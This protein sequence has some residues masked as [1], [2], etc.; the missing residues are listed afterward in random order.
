MA[1]I[2]DYVKWR[3]DVCINENPFNAIDALILTNFGYIHYDEMLES[4][5]KTIGQLGYE[6]QQLTEEKRESKWRVKEDQEL[7]FAMMNSSRYKYLEV[8]DYFSQHDY[9]QEMQFSAMTVHTPDHCI[10]VVFRGTDGSFVGWKEDFNMFSREE[11]P[12][13]CQAV[14]YLKEVAGKYP[15]K[16]IRVMG[17]SKGGNLAIYS[18]VKNDSAIHERM[19]R[20]YN[21]DGPGFSEGF[22]ELDAYKKMRPK[23]QM[24]VPQSS[25]F[26]MIFKHDIKMEIVKS[27]QLGIMQHD[28]YSWEVTGSAFVHVKELSTT[29]KWLENTLDHILENLTVDQRKQLVDIIYQALVDVKGDN[30]MGSWFT[31]I[32][33]FVKEAQALDETNT[34]FLTE[35]IGIF[36]GAAKNSFSETILP[37]KK[38][39]EEIVASHPFY[40]L[41]NVEGA[42]NIRDLGG[43]STPF[44]ITNEHVF[45][46]SD[47][48]THLTNNDIEWLKSYG[49]T[50]IIDLRSTLEKN[51]EPSIFENRSDLTYL[52]IPMLDQIQSNGL[53][54]L[55]SSLFETY[56]GLL[57]GAKKDYKTI[58]EIL[59][60]QEGAVLFHCT[61]GKDR[62]GVLAM[63]LLNLV[64]V[65]QETMVLD[66]AITRQLI[67]PSIRV[68]LDELEKIGIKGVDFL[69]DS[70]PETM[71]QTI[72][73]LNQQ[74]QSAEN[75][76]LS[77]GISIEEIEKIKNKFVK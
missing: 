25:F 1:N 8:S 30:D 67:E 72:D 62:T 26:G 39:N 9:E 16:Q 6:Y 61:A 48:T 69:F 35:S 17:H 31:N 55:P 12:A 47:S 29:S 19:K 20:I 43:Y 49:L 32:K 71:Q 74:Y 57:E 15:E 50:T 64:G 24:V 2:I 68:Q 10:N 21:F 36:V 27:T 3:S 45:L 77:C 63:L 23:I 41:I 4:M 22:L 42:Y 60:N 37:W 40:H 28:A 59:A 14:Q 66:Y 38:V 52:S 56:V 5:V 33:T 46:R 73:Y 75:Y 13:Q 54:N 58:F 51:R 65:D 76:L 53:T 7:L 18:V 70:Q 44:G 11:I 34:N